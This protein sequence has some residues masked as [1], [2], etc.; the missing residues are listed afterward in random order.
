MDFTIILWF[1]GTLFS[2]GIF[3]IKVGLGLRLSSITWKGMFF[4]LLMYLTLFI[5]MSVLSKKLI[6]FLMP[7]LEKGA[8]L[9]ALM[10]VGMILWGVLLLKVEK[11]ES[12]TSETY[13]LNKINKSKH[14]GFNAL[15][16]LIPCP[17]CLTAMVFS[18][19][20]FLN[21][22]QWHAFLVGLTLGIIFIFLSLFVYFLL[23]ITISQVEQENQKIWLGLSMIALGLYFIALLYI[24]AKIEEA[25]GIYNSFIVN[26]LSG[27]DRKQYFF[28]FFLLIISSVAGFI[29]N[30]KKR[31]NL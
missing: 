12:E 9:H 3:A 7:V 2:L 17:V 6:D 5:L 22:V 21:I 14:S 23:R 27:V 1:V 19:W 28:V 20:S 15:L 10:A 25:K 8:L 30:R 18:I 4:T 24:P 31:I 13:F 29:T 11:K 26:G 16:L